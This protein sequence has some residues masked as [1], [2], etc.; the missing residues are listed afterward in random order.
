MEQ[1]SRKMKSISSSSSSSSD[2]RADPDYNESPQRQLQ[3]SSSISSNK[4]KNMK[5]QMTTEEVGTSRGASGSRRRRG[6]P[7]M[8]DNE[9]DDSP[10]AQ[11]T[12]GVT[13]E[14]LS[15]SLRRSTR[16]RSKNSKNKD[17]DRHVKR[18]ILSWLIDTKVIEQNSKVCYMNE[19]RDQA[20]REGIIKR[21]GILCDCCH[22]LFTPLDFEIHAAGS[23]CKRPYE[24]IFIEELQISLL[25][26]LSEAWRRVEELVGGQTFENVKAKSSS[27]DK[28]DDAC[29]ICADGGSLLCCDIC[30]STYHQDCMDIDVRRLF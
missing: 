4:N 2:Q 21:D 11:K 15:L 8:R 7:P 17:D 19:T 6:R 10:N 28:H 25:S 13:D 27:S 3:D 16:R 30:P 12:I 14:R 18:T 22:K 26:C 1:R 9:Q 20:M 23:D 24:N 29:M 5:I